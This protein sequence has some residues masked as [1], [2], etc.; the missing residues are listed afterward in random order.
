MHVGLIPWRTAG[1]KPPPGVHLTGEA[2]EAQ[3]APAVRAARRRVL[4]VEDNLDMVHSTAMLLRDMGHVVEYAINGWAALELARRF[5]PEF[6]LLD[7][8]LPGMDGFELCWRLK[9]E[10]GLEAV[11]CIAVTGY[12]QEDYRRRSKEAGCELHL[13]KPVDPKVLRSLLD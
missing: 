7:L 6:V 9:R 1:G 3:R 2:R 5:R 4:L 12:G 11:R 10:P 8:G 13:L